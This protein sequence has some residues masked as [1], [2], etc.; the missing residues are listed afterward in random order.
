V[1]IEHWVTHLPARDEA[2]SVT[3]AHERYRRL[4]VDYATTPLFV[5]LWQMWQW[6]KDAPLAEP[7]R[8]GAIEVDRGLPESW[9]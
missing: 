4:F 8:F 6:A 1:G 5:G 7:E 3:L 9:R 2:H